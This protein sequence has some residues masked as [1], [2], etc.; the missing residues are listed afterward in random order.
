MLVCF[1][2]LYIMDT[3]VVGLRT[4]ERV[5]YIARDATID[6][7]MQLSSFCVAGQ[8][9]YGVVRMPCTLWAEPLDCTH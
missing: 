5:C 3:P 2:I 7:R 4:Y 9:S 6:R 1:S 8:S